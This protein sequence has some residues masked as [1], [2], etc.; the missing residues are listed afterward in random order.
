M[1]RILDSEIDFQKLEDELE[2]NEKHY[3]YDVGDLK[4][5]YLDYLSR[6][7]SEFFYQFPWQSM[8]HMKFTHGRFFIWAGYPGHFKSTVTAQLALWLAK[9]EKVCLANMEQRKLDMI[10]LM[11]PQ[12]AG[13]H[14][15]MVDDE[16]LDW[17]FDFFKDRF[18]LYENENNMG[19]DRI[20]SLIKLC[21]KK[22]NVR[23]IFI[24]SLMKCGLRHD[25]ITQQTRFVA[26]ICEICRNHSVN[27]HLI[28]HIRKG[29]DENKMPDL[30]DV[31]YAGEITA[32]ADYVILVHEDNSEELK[33]INTL[34]FV[35]C[36]YGK[37]PKY[38]FIF[39]VHE[40]RQ[41]TDLPNG[42]PLKYL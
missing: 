22:K 34:K 26:T 38:P 11:A 40:S 25:D 5:E 30:N 18:Y 41:F 36:K 37:R 20:I 39:R 42:E 16:F 7:D 28:H 3:L 1:D 2:D 35:K 12:V 13:K 4:G 33:T 24:D 10:D 17:F 9:D 19:P 29:F 31:K 32:Q 15:S 8:K 21:A 6:K 27:V 23:H 14:E